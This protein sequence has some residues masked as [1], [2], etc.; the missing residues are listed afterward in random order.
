MKEHF[1]DVH[2]GN[3]PIKSEEPF[4]KDQ[5]IKEP[6]KCN[7]CGF[8]FKIKSQLYGHITS[9]HSD[10]KPFKCNSCNAKYSKKQNLDEHIYQFH[11]DT[12]SDFKCEDCQTIFSKISDLEVHISMVHEE[13]KPYRCGMCGVKYAEKHPLHRHMVV[14]HKA[15]STSKCRICHALFNDVE[16]LKKH[17]VLGHETTV[18]KE[19]IPIT[20]KILRRKTNNQNSDAEN[21]FQCNKCGENFKSGERLK[22]HVTLVHEERKPFGSML[23]DSCISESG[24]NES[25]NDENKSKII[26]EEEE[27]I[28]GDEINS[29]D[30]I[31]S[32]HYED[33]DVEN[34]EID[35]PVLKKVGLKKPLKKVHEKKKPFNCNFCGKEFISKSG[36][37][38]HIS[39][40]HD[41]K[42]PIESIEE[43]VEMPYKCKFCDKRFLSTPGM[44]TLKYSFFFGVRVN[45]INKI[46]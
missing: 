44:L 27:I 40:A 38:S 31:M 20:P 16:D 13:K 28:S 5:T 46:G 3:K 21:P 24:I 42:N 9:M 36:L 25:F 4:Q 11:Q 6:I 14:I 23:D 26:S 15:Q 8:T 29:E 22:A 39:M 30:E 43:N 10:K 17:I 41:G 12:Q 32:E 34:V 18:H 2:D 1:K 45:N 35:P 33:S 7:I 37:K 19:K